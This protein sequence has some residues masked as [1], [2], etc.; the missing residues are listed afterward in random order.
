MPGCRA[1]QTLARAKCAY[2][3]AVPDRRRPAHPPVFERVNSPTIVFVTVCTARRR[4]VLANPDA[5]ATLRSAWRAADT[6]LVGRYVVMP[7]HVHLFCT[8]RTDVTLV[9]WV[10]FWKRMATRWWPDRDLRPVWQRDCWDTQLR[11]EASHDD[12]R[13]YV[14]HNPVRHGL[15]RHPDEWPFEG[16]MNLLDWS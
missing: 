11:T 16:E 7:D 2:A 4:Q 12:K 13:E 1:V 14:R 8:P 6:W 3:V 10:G 15:V 5:V 9:R